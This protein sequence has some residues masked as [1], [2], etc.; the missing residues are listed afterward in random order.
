MGGLT[1]PSIWTLRSTASSAIASRP[2]S[3]RPRAILNEKPVCVSSPSTASVTATHQASV[4]AY[5]A[6]TPA[7]EAIATR[8]TASPTCAGVHLGDA[9]VDGHGAA[10]QVERHL[11]L[12]V[13]ASPRPC[14]RGT[15]RA[16]GPRARSR[17]STLNSS[18]SASAAFSRARRTASRTSSTEGS[19]AHAYPSRSSRIDAHAHAARFGER[20]ALDLAAQGARLG[21]T[22]LLGVGLDR[23]V[24]VAPPPRR[25]AR[26]SSR[27]GTG[28]SHRDAG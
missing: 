9:R 21:L 22:R 6:A 8:L 25:P 27:S 11:H 5:S 26:A 10:L 14:P 4:R 28:A 24:V 16:S 1:A 12:R 13:R 2:S 3:S 7:V 18:G 15:A 19:A 17:G 20:Q 23:L